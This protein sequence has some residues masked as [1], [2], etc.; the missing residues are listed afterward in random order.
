MP[1]AVLKFWFLCASSGAGK[2]NSGLTNLVLISV[3]NTLKNQASLVTSKCLT[4]LLT[5]HLGIQ[6]SMDD[7]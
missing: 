2:P 6:L 7:F 4:A 1:N 5:A 3:L